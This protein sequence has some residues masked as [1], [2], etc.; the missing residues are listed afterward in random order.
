MPIEVELP[1]GS[2]VEFPDGTDNAT[3]ERA[4]SQYRGASAKA[5][6]SGVA[7]SVDS[8]AQNPMGRYQLG[9]TPL[10]GVSAEQLAQANSAR[11]ATFD[12]AAAAAA[13]RENRMQAFQ[14]APMAGQ[15]AAGAGSRVASGAMGVG[16]VLGLADEQDAARQA[17]QMSF[18]DGSGTASLGKIGGDIALLTAPGG[19][20]GRI[21]SLA[22]RIAGNAALGAGY[23]AI[24]PVADDESRLQNTAVGGI[25]GGLGGAAQG[26]LS[27]VA[28]RARSAVDPIRQR[29]MDVAR[30]KGIPLH[31]SQL[32][33]SIPMKTAA[34]IAKYLPFSGAGAAAGRQQSQFNRAVGRT[35]GVD[36][37][38]FSD[39]VMSLAR[40]NLSNQFESVYNRNDIQMTP[41][42][43]GKLA[44]INN[45]ASRRLTRDEAAVVANQLD[46]V[47][48]ELDQ[49]GI[50]TG[51]KYQ[52]LRTQIMKAE[53]PDKVGQA[54]ASLRKGLDDI[55]A[56]AVGDV[57]A[58]H[59]R[60]LRSQ[61]SNF[62]TAENVLKQVAGAGGDIRPASLWPAIRK[63]STREMRDLARVGQ[64]LL[65][66]PI[67]DS[68]TQGRWMAGSLLGGGALG[69]G[70]E[71]LLPLTGLLASGAT[72]G[73]V[74]N[75]GLLAGAVANPGQGALALS[76][77][78]P[79]GAILVAPAVTPKSK[80]RRN[81]D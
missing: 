62:R 19:V 52:A 56:D 26:L 69:G 47:V 76:R 18:M 42:T 79:A 81:D 78:A 67:P 21:P 27:G 25:A 9:G 29:A 6:F 70:A 24:D 61:W 64:V 10:P 71:T 77:A 33:Q 63:G 20:I 49:A 36:V 59:L 5:D 65:K 74:L 31:I 75:S 12:P 55:A 45:A 66:D 41:E 68:G 16:Q 15:F 60:Q 28:S 23:G 48:A 72:V 39:D 40:R 53:G 51:Q 3:M 43:L 57:D 11:R 44:S 1:D 7:G 50:L 8:T 38:Q 35:F 37:P 13:D 14:Q 17:E 32:S 30:E 22:G 58:A 54:V 2:V 73:R 46:D 4:L 34:S 80:R